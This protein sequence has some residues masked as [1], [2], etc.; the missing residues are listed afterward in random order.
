M[1]KLKK[2]KIKLKENRLV[3]VYTKNIYMGEDLERVKDFF[4]TVNWEET[5]YILIPS[6]YVKKIKIIKRRRK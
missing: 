5:P 3:V 4:E 6:E 2:I 1:K